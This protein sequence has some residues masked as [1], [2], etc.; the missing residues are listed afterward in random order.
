MI[1]I[2]APFF[3]AEQLQSVKTVE[4]I[5]GR[6]GMKFFSPRLHGVNVKELSPEEQKSGSVMA[7]VFESNVSNLNDANLLLACIDKDPG[8]RNGD[9]GTMFELGYYSA[10]A[11]PNGQMR[12]P[13][14]LSWSAR[15]ATTNLM[16]R[17]VVGGSFINLLQVEEFFKHVKESFSEEIYDG[18]LPSIAWERINMQYEA[19]GNK[20][21]VEE[22]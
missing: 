3:N 21:T 4:N 7:K 9:A 11:T 2:A 6:A 15:G 17:E 13:T 19:F 12:C 10:V 18:E 16:I 8:Q 1:Y 14:A 20:P 22:A 5:L